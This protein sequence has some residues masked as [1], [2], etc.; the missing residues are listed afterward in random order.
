VKGMPPTA[1]LG[2]QGDPVEE[3]LGVVVKIAKAFGLQAVGDHAEEQMP[4][5]M[6]GGLAAEH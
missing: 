1:L 2:T 4:A 5:Q 6:V 3:A